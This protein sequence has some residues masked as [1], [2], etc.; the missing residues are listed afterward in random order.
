M[1]RARSV[2]LSDRAPNLWV[3]EG[4]EIPDSAQV[5]VNVVIH[6]GVVLGEECHLEDGVVLGKVARPNRGSKS[7]VPEA[8]PTLVGAGS[9][10]GAYTV[11]NAGATLGEEGSLG[12][13]MLVRA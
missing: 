4:V 8:L 7:P 10:V 11:V 5:G 12:D 1:S 9:V 2:R 6:P 3:A 13:H